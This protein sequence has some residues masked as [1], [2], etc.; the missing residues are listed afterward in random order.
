MNK[1]IIQGHM[2]KDPEMRYT[3]NGSAVASFEIECVETWVSS[4]GEN[5]SVRTWIRCVAW[6]Q[7]AEYVT[8]HGHE[9]AEAYVMGR[10][11]TRSY[12][13]KNGQKRYVTE[14]VARD[15]VIL[16]PPIG[17]GR[18][19]DG[20]TVSSA[21]PHPGPKAALQRAQDDDDTPF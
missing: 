6:G 21:Q 19:P 9:V 11:Q 2:T 5:K 8:E 7:L 18:T 17:V 14:I 13:D 12:E 16:T 15:V 1:A 4:S 20:N 10:I 3:G